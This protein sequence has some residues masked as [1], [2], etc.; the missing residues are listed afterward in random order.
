VT[1]DFVLWSFYAYF[2]LFL[3]VEFVFTRFRLGSKGQGNRDRLSFLF[4]GIAPFFGMFLWRAAINHGL[5]PATPTWPQWI[6]GMALG[7]AGFAVRMIA[8]RTLGRFFTVRV[9]LQDH[10]EVVD[11]GIYGA[12]RHPL[13]LGF[14]LEWLAPPLILGS[15]AGFLFTTLW[16]VIGVLHR[17]PHEEALLTEGLGDEYR[18][19]MG[20]TKRLIPGVW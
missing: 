1:E 11:T 18:A 5:V 13:Y 8:K 4:F 14:I 2:A 9:Q 16:I 12:V 7:L 20:R 6:L 17:I 10:H 3:L 19:Y 15:P